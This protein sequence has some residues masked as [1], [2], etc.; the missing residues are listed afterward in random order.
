MLKR[1]IEN[2]LISISERE[3]D[4]P[5][6]LLLEAEGHTVINTTTVHGPMELGKDVVSWHP[7]EKTFYF[8]QLKAGNI[9]NSSWS[10]M[11]RQVMQLVTVPLSL[12]HI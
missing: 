11:E 7:E 10:E 6:R 3:F 1:V 9:T 2:W 8:F 4:I 12:I 5:F